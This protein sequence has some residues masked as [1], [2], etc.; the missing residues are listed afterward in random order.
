MEKHKKRTVKAIKV[1]EAGYLIAKHDLQVYYAHFLL[2]GNKITADGDRIIS[3]NDTLEYMPDKPDVMHYKK[4]DEIMSKEEYSALKSYYD[5]EDS[6]DEVLQA[7]ENKKK[8]E[9][10]EPVYKDRKPEPVEIEIIGYS[11]ETG[12]KFISSVISTQQWTKHPSLFT[13]F[14][15]QVVMDEYKNLSKQYANHAKFE[16]PDRPYLRFTEINGNF[17]FH[18]GA[19]F[20]D[21]HHRRSFEKLEEAKEYEE[22]L[23]VSVRDVVLN[24]VF[25]KKMTEF[26]RTQIIAR[27]ITAKSLNKDAMIQVVESIIDDLSDYGNIILND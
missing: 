20:N 3:I 25:P 8:K 18:D 9:G 13:V 12:S 6:D 2:N 16:K 15:S 17:A 11:Q 5:E 1:G 21:Y 10:F 23:R 14:G 24:V 4:G 22:T 7:I 26:K 19:P 27:L